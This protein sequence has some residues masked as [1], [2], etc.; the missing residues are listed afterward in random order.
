MCIRLTSK[1]E[2]HIINS[3][4]S[5]PSENTLRIEPIKDRKILE[6][7]T[8]WKWMIPLNVPLQIIAGP[9][10][11]LWYIH[12]ISR[13]WCSAFISIL[14]SPK[15]TEFRIRWVGPFWNSHAVPS[16]AQEWFRT[17]GK[18]WSENE[19]FFFNGKFAKRAEEQVKTNIWNNQL[20]KRK[21]KN[22]LLWWQPGKPTLLRQNIQAHVIWSK[23]EHWAEEVCI[24]WITRSWQ[25][26]FNVDILGQ[27]YRTHS[28]R[29]LEN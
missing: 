28:V 12:Q 15:M 14:T 27:I 26:S 21:N 9:I 8:S 23:C 22:A 18:T 7:K 13:L 29:C 16:L 17:G 3:W 20:I 6:N 19:W 25:Y 4:Q 2:P 11:F 5:L 24:W 1:Y 10:L